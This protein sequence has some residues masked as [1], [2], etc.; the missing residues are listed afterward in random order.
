MAALRAD[1]ADVSEMKQS[2]LEMEAGRSQ[3]DIAARDMEFH[4]LIARATRNEIILRIF[5]VMRAT[6]ARMFEDNVARMGNEGVEYHRRILLAIQTRDIRSARQCML[7]HL[8]D[9]MRFV[10]RP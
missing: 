1:S 4:Y 7:D 10:C 8:D 9:T 2:I 3:A 6:Y 5:E